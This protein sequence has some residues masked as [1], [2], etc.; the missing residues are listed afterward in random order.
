MALRLCA[1]GVAAELAERRALNHRCCAR[2]SLGGASQRLLC[3]GFGVDAAAA[4]DRGNRRPPMSDVA[5]G[6]ASARGIP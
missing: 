6:I 4:V 1:Q 5:S 2:V 3:V